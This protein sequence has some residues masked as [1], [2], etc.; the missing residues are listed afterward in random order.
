MGHI[1]LGSTQSSLVA[2]D[3]T[4]H[5]SMISYDR[6]FCSR[7]KLPVGCRIGGKHD[8]GDIETTKLFVADA[9]VAMLRGD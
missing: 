1:S 8:K 3:C 9:E 6:D 2:F 7:E 5:R 4:L